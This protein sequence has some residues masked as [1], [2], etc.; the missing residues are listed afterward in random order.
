MNQGYGQPPP[1]YPQAQPEAPQRVIVTDFEMPFFSMM[2][3]MIKP[4][5]AALPAAF[6]IGLV[7]GG[8]N[9][10]FAGCVAAISG[11]H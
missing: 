2:G 4:A 3:F 9:V 5:L 1:Q 10:A 11:S 6:I 8:M 7:F